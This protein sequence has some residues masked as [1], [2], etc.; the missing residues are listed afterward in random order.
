[1]EPR[2]KQQKTS[3]DD[4]RALTQRVC[5][6]FDINET[7][8]VGDPA[9]GD[10]F[11]ESLNK[12]LAKVAFVKAA[13]PEAQKGGRW[14]EWTWHDGSPLDPDL[15]APDAPLPPLLTEAF[16]D[17][18]GC[19][20]FYNVKALKGPFAK[21]FTEASSPGSIYRAKFESLRNSLKWPEDV[22]VDSRLCSEE[23][24]YHIMPAFF[25][26]LASL[27]TSGK[28]FTVVLR[29]FGTDL[30]RVQQAIN[31][32]AEGAH[33]LHKGAVCPDLALPDSRMWRGRY[34]AADGGFTLIPYE[35]DSALDSLREGVS[36]VTE[37]PTSVHA[38]RAPSD[39][40]A[41]GANG[42][43]NGAA[44]GRDSA[45]L[46]SR[47]PSNVPTPRRESILDEG[48]MLAELQ[49]AYDGPPRVSAVQDDYSWWKGA[50]YAPS[51]GKPLWLTYEPE[52]PCAWRHLFFDDN[53][54]HDAKDSIVAVRARRRA[55]EPFKP[56]SGES[57]IKL[58]ATVLLK[59]PTVKPIMEPGWFLEQLD[60]CGARYEALRSGRATGE[61]GS[62]FAKMLELTQS[63]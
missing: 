45:P 51:S 5:V 28:P 53:I 38:T 19:K 4:R 1:M 48:A 44:N 6:H 3:A 41:I 33:P 8:L 32:F 2:P 36:I 56:V 60:A 31:A 12:V 17:P 16:A 18:P 9:G 13:P 7:I 49:G 11:E 57:T 30:P 59:V 29:T 34:G 22:A 26:T 27:R 15:R 23:G 42:N 43:G 58:H 63:A 37:S 35:E 52:A 62:S 25:Q 47:G 39:T 20:R 14:P 40:S 21:K 55:G 54:H 10:S 46:P 24:Y 61:D 50:G